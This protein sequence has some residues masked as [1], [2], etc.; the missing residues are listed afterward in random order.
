M[1]IDEARHKELAFLQLN[2]RCAKVG[3]TALCEY[4]LKLGA[5]YIL[6]N[7]IDITI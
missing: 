3:I 1:G 4:I 2:E 7:P 5:L 6:V